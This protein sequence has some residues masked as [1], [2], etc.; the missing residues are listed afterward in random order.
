MVD[1]KEL[2]EAV[3]TTVSR[4]DVRYVVGYERGTYGFE[5]APSFAY[6][7][8][9]SDK[10]IFNPLC[11]K[12]LV[13]YPILEEKLPLGKDEQADTRKIGVVVRGCDSR[14]AVQIIQE[15]GLKR[16]NLVLIGIP[17]PGVIEPKK[18]KK[19]FPNQVEYTDVKEEKNQYLF[20]AHLHPCCTYFMY[21]CSIE[22]SSVSKWLIVPISPSLF[23]MS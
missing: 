19:R 2:V 13:A 18:I 7:A 1:Q 10:F 3:N 9:D 12:N 15:K 20:T 17:C 6:S 16:E 5:T 4:E 8:E 21:K 23:N 22:G 14:A 11:T